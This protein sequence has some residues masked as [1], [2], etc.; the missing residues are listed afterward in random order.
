[1]F[2]LGGF[3]FGRVKALGLLGASGAEGVGGL[4]CSPGNLVSEGL[5][6]RV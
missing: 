2:T 5:G 6:F 1:M 4:K 3:G